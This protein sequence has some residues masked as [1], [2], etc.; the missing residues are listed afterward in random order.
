MYYYSTHVKF[1]LVLLNAS[2]DIFTDSLTHDVIANVSG[3]LV[4][5]L[6]HKWSDNK[7]LMG[8]S[9]IPWRAMP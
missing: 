7:A 2:N 3:Q 5:A 4:H 9:Q 1:L 8:I 6:L